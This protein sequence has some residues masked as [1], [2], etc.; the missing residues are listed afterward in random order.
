MIPDLEVMVGNS[1]E[2]LSEKAIVLLQNPE[3][4]KKMAQQA[5]LKIKETYDWQV[6]AQKTILFYNSLN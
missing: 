2:E 6:I 3:L 1:P 5:L 4:R